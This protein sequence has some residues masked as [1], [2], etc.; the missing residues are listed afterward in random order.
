MHFP[1][2]EMSLSRASMTAFGESV[3]KSMLFV[4]DC[5]I[6]PLV[7]PLRPRSEEWQGRE[8]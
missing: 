6:R 2:R 7:F 1:G 8:K 5:R 3:A 4:N